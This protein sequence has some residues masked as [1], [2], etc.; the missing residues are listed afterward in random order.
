MAQAFL[1]GL[2]TSFPEKV[3]TNQQ[4][5]AENPDWDMAR[6]EAKT[7]IRARHIVAKEECASDLAFSA[8]EK[9]IAGMGLDRSRIDGLL[10][11]T[12]SPDF[13]LPTTA[14]ILQHRLG[15]STDCA[16][17][18]FNQGCSG[19][20]YGLYLAAGLV[21]S[22]MANNVLLLTAET[23]SKYIHPRDRSARVLFGD[24]AA[25]T[26]VTSSGDGARIGDFALGTDGSGSANLI[27]PVG[28]ARQPVC[29]GGRTGRT[30]EGGSVRTD[31]NLFMDGQE[32][33]TFTLKRVPEVISNL[34]SKTK[35]TREQVNWFIFHQANAF[36]NERLRAKLHIPKESAP[37][38]LESY[39][40]T[41][42]STIPITMYEYATKFVVGE[43]VMLVGFGVGYS[44]GACLLEWDA[45]KL[46]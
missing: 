20:V 30:D 15:L 35:L 42:S 14:C 31:E 41:V 12:Q 24:A 43:K 18:D 5:Q 37:V 33:F 25:A 16:A 23:Y 19:Y 1:S 39:G 9:L 36:M 26:L 6:I 21:R 34:L 38:A 28:G 29:L 46:A 40:N 27:V 2:A 7:G 3:V 8:A 44:W 32:L 22:G 4:L 13:Y 11:C 17:L 10:L 45:V